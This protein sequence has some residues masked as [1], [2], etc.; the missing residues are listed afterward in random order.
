MYPLN[1][2]QLGCQ[3]YLNKTEF[4]RKER[5]KEKAKTLPLK[6]S[7]QHSNAKKKF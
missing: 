3:L 4:F 2:L 1:I 7:T 5:K 6:N